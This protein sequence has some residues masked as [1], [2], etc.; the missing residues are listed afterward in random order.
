MSDQPKTKAQ[1]LWAAL[2]C[3][4]AFYAGLSAAHG[5][6]CLWTDYWYLYAPMA[7]LYAGL[8]LRG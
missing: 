4:R 1:A 5:N 2:T 6:C 3:H 8:A 7:A